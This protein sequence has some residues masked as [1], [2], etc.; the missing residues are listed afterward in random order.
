MIGQEDYPEE[1][2]SEDASC[3]LYYPCMEDNSHIEELRRLFLTAPLS[4]IHAQIP[5]IRFSQ[6]PHFPPC[7]CI[8]PAMYPARRMSI[9][10][11]RGQKAFSPSWPG[12]FPFFRETM[13]VAVFLPFAL[14]GSFS[15][16]RAGAASVLSHALFPAM[17]FVSGA[18]SCC[19]SSACGRPLS[20]FRR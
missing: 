3:H 5:G 2:G 13:S 19:R 8:S 4:P 17:S 14:I 20:S 1:L 9:I 15:L 10:P 16:T 11:Q 12:M 7:R 6:N 18:C